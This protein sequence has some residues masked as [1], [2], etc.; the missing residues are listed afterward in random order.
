MCVCT[1]RMPRAALGSPGWA[2]GAESAATRPSGSGSGAA[3]AAVSGISAP[4]RR[5]ES[6]RPWGAPSRPLV[7]PLLPVLPAHQRDEAYVEEAALVDAVRR[8]L[9]DAEVLVPLAHRD[10][11]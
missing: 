11:E 2:A 10:H 1:C 8:A 4:R 6:G 3:R 9:V 5:A 7:R